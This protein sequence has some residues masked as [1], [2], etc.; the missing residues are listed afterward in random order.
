VGK[1][2]YFSRAAAWPL[3]GT[4]CYINVPFRFAFAAFFMKQHTIDSLSFA[5]V[6]NNKQ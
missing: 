2:V 4:F 5:F 3:P 6:Y 1:A